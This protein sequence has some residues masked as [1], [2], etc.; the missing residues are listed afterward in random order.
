MND[1]FTTYK[2]EKAVNDRMLN[3]Q[4]EKLQEQLSAVRSQ[5]AK[6]STQLEFAF[7]R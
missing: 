2:N 5:K 1:S 3:E 7:K 4:N 6:L